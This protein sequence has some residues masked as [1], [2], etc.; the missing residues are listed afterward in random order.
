METL[1]PVLFA[2]LSNDILI[3]ISPIEAM[4][5]SLRTIF[6]KTLLLSGVYLL[7]GGEIAAQYAVPGTPRSV[8][9]GGLRAVDESS[10]RDAFSTSRGDTLWVSPPLESDIE[11]DS[12]QTSGLLQFAHNIET[13]VSMAEHGSWFMDASGSYVWRCTIASRGAL[14][15]GFRLDGYQ[16]PSGASLYLYG[17]DGRVYGAFTEINNNDRRTLQI[18]PI[19]GSAITLE[20]ELPSGQKPSRE[21]QQPFY[22]GRI[23]YGFRNVLGLRRIDR[24]AYGFAYGE[25]Y[26]DFSHS[27][28][29]RLACAPNILAYP[30]CTNQGRSVVLM[31]VDGSSVATGAL[32]NNTRQDGTAYLLTSAHCVNQNYKNE[33]DLATIHRTA[34]EA[35]F[36]FG[37]DSPLPN[38]NIRPS[39]EK[40]LSGAEVVAY[41]PEAD[42]A[43][44][45]IT[46][47]PTDV[48]G[49]KRIPAS[50]NPYFA[51]WS[52]EA[53]PSAPY[54][55]IHHPRATTKRYSEVEGISL[56]IEDYTVRVGYDEVTGEDRYK[57]W[58]GKHWYI[59][60]WLVG[61]TSGGSSGSPLF[62]GAGRI[63]GALTGGAS[64]CSN[65]RNDYYWAVHRT[66][67][68]ASPQVS[69]RPHLDP[70][71]T[72]AMVLEGYD[73]LASQPVYRHSRLYARQE[74]D[75]LMVYE[76]TGG[77]SG[78]GRRLHLSKSG[79]PLGAYLVFAGNEALQNQFP[80]LVVELRAVEGDMVGAVKWRTEVN[81]TPFVRYDEAV[82]DFTTDVRTLQFDSIELFIPSRES[83][84]LPAGDYILGVR[85]S[86]GT[87]LTL[88]LLANRERQTVKTE[89]DT[90]WLMQSGVWHKGEDAAINYWV[91]LL[92]Q[93]SAQG[94][95][96]TTEGIKEFR[97][98][99]HGGKLYAYNPETTA[100]E[101]YIYAFDGMLIQRASLPHGESTVGLDRLLAGHNYIVR[102][103]GQ[104]GKLTLKVAGSSR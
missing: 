26:Y 90:P 18:A 71:N 89:Q 22:V 48:D 50:Y 94:D 96:D 85:S 31:V 38:L 93:S 99:A 11:R 23:S 3:T 88:S 13:H 62:D 104:S 39:E 72:G 84:S 100:A 16:L 51:G 87:D 46:G 25:P 54:F 66:W 81:A 14:N 42:M 33:T 79:V 28:L 75:N 6:F 68:G 56:S 65:P 57:T 20:Y 101:V 24:Q 17:P 52:R 49:Q 36:F 74:L 77:V 1:L 5:T 70:D 41:A 8:R 44:L 27:W 59:P 83:P 34:A 30:E 32:I 69:L 61:T 21:M 86:D 76:Q 73:P 37:F 40:S 58:I 103:V 55:G 67:T 9:A 4:K 29:S 7:G 43:L 102:I 82:G 95:W 60:R 92:V 15:L 80:S 19:E 12:K 63:I 98:F 78:L 47:L 97:A 53:S 10:D 35:V 45:R 64:S 91:D 2:G